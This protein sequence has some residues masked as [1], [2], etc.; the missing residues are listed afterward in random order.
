MYVKFVHC[1]KVIARA[2]RRRSLELELPLERLSVGNRKTENRCLYKFV[3][4]LKRSRLVPT[5]RI[6]ANS[7]N[8]SGAGHDQVRIYRMFVWA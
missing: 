4:F 8:I 6:L 1:T 7:P 3:Q 2:R 5:K